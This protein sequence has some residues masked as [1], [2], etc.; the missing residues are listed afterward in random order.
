M[1]NVAIFAPRVFTI[2]DT[3]VIATTA[4]AVASMVT[5]EP[6]TTAAYIPARIEL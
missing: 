3:C 4:V 6:L 5:T 1:T 2:T